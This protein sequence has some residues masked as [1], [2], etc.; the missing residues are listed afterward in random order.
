MRLTG[1]LTG[2]LI[3]SAACGRTIPVVQYKGIDDKAFHVEER[4]L[5]DKPDSDPIPEDKNYAHP[6]TK[7]QSAPADGVL[8]SPEKSA[9]ALKYKVGYNEILNLYQADRDVWRHNRAIYEERLKQANAEIKRLAPDWWA[10]HIG[11]I[12]FVG[13]LIFGSMLS[14]GIVYGVREAKGQ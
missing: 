2:I 1:L 11:S 14:V 8:L 12:G 9:R 6:L 13:G 3:F 4:A 5:P 7:G 10:A